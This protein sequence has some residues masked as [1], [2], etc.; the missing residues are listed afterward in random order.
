MEKRHLR[1]YNEVSCRSLF[2][3]AAAHLSDTA[4]LIEYYKKPRLIECSGNKTNRTNWNQI[5][6]LP[7]A[8][9]LF[10]SLRRMQLEAN[11]IN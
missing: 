3:F 9:P 2:S 4:L 11:M 5:A 10:I 1:V 7:N 8:S 6:Q